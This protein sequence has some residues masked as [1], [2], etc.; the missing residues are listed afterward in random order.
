MIKATDFPNVL[1]YFVSNCYVQTSS[2]EIEKTKVSIFN[3]YEC[4]NPIFGDA[5]SIFMGRSIKTGSTTD[6]KF[7]FPA[8]TF[9]TA[10]NDQIHMVSFS[11]S[12]LYIFLNVPL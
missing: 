5:A 12:V 7:S 8:F 6:Y 10:E 2:D 4:Y 3:N 1:Q 11:A 9:N